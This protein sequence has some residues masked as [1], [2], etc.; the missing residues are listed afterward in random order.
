MKLR[1]LS[2]PALAFTLLAAFASTTSAQSSGGGGGGFGGGGFGGGGSSGSGSGPGGG[3]ITPAPPDITVLVRLALLKV[4]TTRGF[5]KAV[6]RDATGTTADGN[7]TTTASGFTN[8]TFVFD[9]SA[10]PNSTHDGATITFKFDR[11][12]S[13]TW[14][15]VKG[16]PG[17]GIGPVN[18][19]VLPVMTLTHALQIIRRAHD[20]DG[21]NE[22]ELVDILSPG[23][24]QPEYIFQ[25]PTG[26]A[27]VGTRTAAVTLIPSD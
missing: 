10:S 2:L 7:T 21:F 11:Y 3:F 8:W 5:S 16:T 6:L 12:P 18:I 14:S 17:I 27:I 4:K 1:R 15:K 24:N 25:T 13:G 20:L 9:N 22:V 26:E 23:P 19:P